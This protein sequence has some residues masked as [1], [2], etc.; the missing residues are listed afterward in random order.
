MNIL[1]ILR[2]IIDTFSKH[3]YILIS[4][5]SF[6]SGIQLGPER[7]QMVQNWSS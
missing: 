2:I 6:L 7:F 5:F 3:T 4:G 1:D